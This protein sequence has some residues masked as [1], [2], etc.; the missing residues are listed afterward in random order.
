MFCKNPIKDLIKEAERK[1]AMRMNERMKQKGIM[2][3]EFPAENGNP[4]VFQARAEWV[5]HPTA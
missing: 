1:S 4:G 3:P 2:M 5:L